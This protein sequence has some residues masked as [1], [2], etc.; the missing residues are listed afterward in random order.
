MSCTDPVGG[1]CSSRTIIGALILL[2]AALGLSQWAAGHARARADADARQNARA[3]ASLLES[4]LQKFRPAAAR[5]QR[6]PRRPPARSPTRAPRRRGGSTA[7]SSSS[8]RRTDAAVIYVIGADGMTIAASN[9]KAGTS[10]VGQDY[11]FRPY[12]RGAMQR[13]EAEMFALGTVSGRPGLFL[14]R[15]VDVGGRPLGVIVVKVEF[16]KL[17]AK[18]AD[19]PRQRW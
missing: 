9:W 6:I 7:N 5:A 10:F 16:D 11:R 14:A 2:A 1:G 13:G 8:R 17:E 12:F 4:E 15:R 3:H 19:S 18:W